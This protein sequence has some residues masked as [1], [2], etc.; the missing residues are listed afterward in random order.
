MK[1]FHIQSHDGINTEVNRDEYLKASKAHD[2]QGKEL[3][4]EFYDQK[5]MN[6]KYYPGNYHLL[7]PV[8]GHPEAVAACKQFHSDNSASHVQTP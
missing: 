4:Y 3:Y 2:E 5:E 1:T 7:I 6:Q 8:N